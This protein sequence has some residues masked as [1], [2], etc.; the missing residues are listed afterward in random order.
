MFLCSCPH[1]VVERKKIE[2]IVTSKAATYH[3]DL[4]KN[5]SHL[6]AAAPTGE[7]YEF[8][9]RNGITVVTIEW[10][11]HSLER[12]MALE[13]AFYDPNLPKDRIGVG[14]RPLQPAAPAAVGVV[15]FA[16]SFFV[17]WSEPYL[18]F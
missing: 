3:P 8:A 14:S 11:Y 17:M 10:L 13:E 18:I 12:G 1:T 16:W 5:V 15:S 6:I 4:T 2:E 7:K 9:I